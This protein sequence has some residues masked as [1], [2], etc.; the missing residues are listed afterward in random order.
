MIPTARPPAK[1]FKVY[2]YR[3]D[4]QSSKLAPEIANFGV[5]QERNFSEEDLTIHDKDKEIELTPQT[6][7]R[8]VEDVARKMLLWEIGRAHV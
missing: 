5:P 2:A 8:F 1:W 3:V 4:K 6:T 7:P